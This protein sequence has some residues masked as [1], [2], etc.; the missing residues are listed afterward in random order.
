MYF[1]FE[2]LEVWKDAK[3]FVNEIYGATKSFPKDEQFGL[4]SQIRRAALSVLLN[5]TE[6][7]DRKSDAELKRFLRIS[8]TSV[9]E[10]IA[11]LYIAKDQSMIDQPEFSGL[12]K[13][14]NEIVARINSLIRTL[15]QS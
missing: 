3:A 9:E 8:I 6:G 5:I 4:T 15:S 2:N 11:A 1:R 13:K 7:S 14:A 12:Y 10:V